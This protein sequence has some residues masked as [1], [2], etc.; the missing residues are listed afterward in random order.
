M[1]SFVQEN[2]WFSTSVSDLNPNPHS[3]ASWI[4]IR[5]ANADQE[6]ENQPPPKKK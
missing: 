5:I 4:R 6:G 3:M 1:S 2:P